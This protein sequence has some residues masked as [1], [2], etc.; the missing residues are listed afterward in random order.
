MFSAHIEPAARSWTG[1]L[2]SHQAPHI[3]L[4]RNQIA[5]VGKPVVAATNIVAPARVPSA[6]RVGRRSRPRNVPHDLVVRA[7]WAS[8]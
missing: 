1:A 2:G 7:E 5:V 6:I 3:A 4:C 8:L